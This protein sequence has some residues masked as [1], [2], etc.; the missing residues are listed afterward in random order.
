[1]KF[2]YFHGYG[3][4]AA[5]GSI[6]TLRIK[7]PDYEVITSDIPVVAP[8]EALPFMKELCSKEQP[9]VIVGISMG[10]MYASFIF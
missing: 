10:G 4:S 3:S 8:A 1:M 2:V 9:N 7:L 6:Q 5:S